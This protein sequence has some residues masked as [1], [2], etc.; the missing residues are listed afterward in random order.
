M[1][2]RCNKSSDLPVSSH[3]SAGAEKEHKALA[4]LFDSQVHGFDRAASSL[5][6]GTTILCFPT[7]EINTDKYF[8]IYKLWNIGLYTIF[9][10][11]LF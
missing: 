6:L 8:S 3:Y 10:L 9:C 4:C 1:L 11:L 5:L 7:N 2:R